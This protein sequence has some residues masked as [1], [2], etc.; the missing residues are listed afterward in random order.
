MISC[1]VRP[2]AAEVALRVRVALTRER[3]VEPA[4]KGVERQRAEPL[5]N[6]KL[7]RVVPD[8]L[9]A[10]DLAKGLLGVLAQLAEA[11]CDHGRNTFALS[12][13]FAAAARRAA[14]AIRNGR[15][16]HGTGKAHSGDQQ[17]KS[18]AAGALQARGFGLLWTALT[19]PHPGCV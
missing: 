3:A 13:A 4:R 16:R 17:S 15:F 18:H 5:R 12:F 6:L 8:G 1:S 14:R 10:K 2:S 9:L 7:E 19:A 11:R